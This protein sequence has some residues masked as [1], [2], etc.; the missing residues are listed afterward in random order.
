MVYGNEGQSICHRNAFAELTSDDQPTDQTGSRRRGHP[1]QIRKSDSG[2]GHCPAHLLG[3]VPQVR[4]GGDFW[5]DPAEWR[6][7]GKLAKH[8]LGQNPPVA[9]DDRRSRLVTRCLDS[10]NRSHS[11]FPA[12]A[13][14][15]AHGNLSLSLRVEK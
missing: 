15:W 7:F 9:I 10:Q 5:H 12:D 14:A 1:G 11:T 4:S 13:L 8:R 2:G 6:M 3:Q